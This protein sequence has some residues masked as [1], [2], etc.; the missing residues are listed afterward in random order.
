MAMN[1]TQLSELKEFM[2]VEG[3]SKSTI[4]QYLDC[5]RRVQDFPEGSC[6][7]EL[8][9]HIKK[10]VRRRRQSF[11]ES[12][13][14]D[15][16]AAANLWFRMKTGI[17]VRRYE[18]TLKPV[19]RFDALLTSFHDH[20]INMKQI[21]AETAASECSHVQEFLEFAFH[22]VEDIV[23]T[24]ITAWTVRDYVCTKIAA[25]LDSSKGRYITSIRNFFRFLEFSGT[26]VHPSVFLLPLSPVA[27]NSRRTPVTLTEEEVGRLLA[28]FEGDSAK[29]KRN[30]AIF[31][32]LLDLGLRCSE[33][34]QLKLEDILWNRG[35][36][37][38]RETKTRRERLL[39]LSARLGEALED[40]VIG[41]RGNGDDR[42]LFLRI[43]RFEG[44]PMDREGVRRI[45]RLAFHKLQIGGW[46][47]GTHA[48]RRTT[49]S[50]IYNSGNSLKLTADVLGHS[51][52]DAITAYTKID[53]HSLRSL[54][55]AW[56]KGG[57]SC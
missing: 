7:R 25:L 12:S 38:V 52:I 3:Y 21:A 34:P 35:E 54:V 2:E 44:Q 27:W 48:I 55:G 39:P 37:L 41:H 20:S 22:G 36:L 1:I 14:S 40:Y 49:A 30:R 46:W 26:P 32:M 42:H 53:E 11:S 28:Y 45:I 23:F 31:L 51:G 8:Y 4:R 24:D 5:L 13:C 6:E 56:P 10:L 17:P 19:G 33:V 29:K 47:K 43:G 15:L 50:K 18:Q 57:P 16:R 9:E